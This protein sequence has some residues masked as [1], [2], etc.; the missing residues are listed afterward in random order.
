MATTEELIEEYKQKRAKIEQ[1]ASP[2]AIEKRHKAGQWT[3]RERIEY[4][5][6]TDT[7][8]E[9]GLFVKHRTTA[10]GITR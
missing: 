9:I 5:F 1:M 8:T 3:A 7:F 2:D 4:F 10:F 6:D